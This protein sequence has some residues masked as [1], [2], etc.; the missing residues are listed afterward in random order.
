MKEKS[1]REQITKEIDF[2]AEH[3][4]EG[5]DHSPFSFG[6][7][8]EEVVNTILSKFTTMIEEMEKEIHNNLVKKMTVNEA[9]EC[10]SVL[11]KYKKLLQ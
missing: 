2:L 3:W 9:E 10:L 7:W 5:D 1:I 6:G 11:Q 4:V 8:K